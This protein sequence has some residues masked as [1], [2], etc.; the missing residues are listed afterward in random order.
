MSGLWKIC[1]WSHITGSHYRRAAGIY[2]KSGLIILP[3]RRLAAL[4]HLIWRYRQKGLLVSLLDLVKNTPVEDSRRLTDAFIVGSSGY[5]ADHYDFGLAC[6]QLSSTLIGPDRAGEIVINILLPFVYAQGIIS[7]KALEIYRRYPALPANSIE[8]H[9]QKQLGLGK[10][11]INSACRQ[12][13]L[14]HIY[15]TLCTQG[16]CMECPLS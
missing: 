7:S 8:K 4:S 11:I 13:G 5:W 2:L 15:K 9:L 14:I 10:G 12:Q 6:A 3:L 1:G 16:K